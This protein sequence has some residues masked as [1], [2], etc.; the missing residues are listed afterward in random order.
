M[1]KRREEMEILI[2]DTYGMSSEAFT[3]LTF[4]LGWKMVKRRRNGNRSK[5]DERDISTTRSRWYPNLKCTSHLPVR[6]CGRTSPVSS[7]VRIV[8]A[9]VP[10]PT[11]EPA[12]AR[13]SQTLSNLTTSHSNNISEMTAAADELSQIEEREKEL[14]EAIENTEIQRSWFTAFREFLEG[15][16][17]FLEEKVKCSLLFWGRNANATSSIP[18]WRSSRRSTSLFSKR[19]SI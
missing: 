4:R 7:D 16:A 9:M 15:V 3:P 14:R 2:A 6:A 8:P 5:Y 19:D 17:H 11:L 13:L 18:L 10:I 12:I 1:K